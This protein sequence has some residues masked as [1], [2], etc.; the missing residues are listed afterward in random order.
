MHEFPHGGLWLN[1][2]IHMGECYA[3]AHPTGEVAEATMA[4]EQTAM[5]IAAITPTAPKE[6]GMIG[7]H[8]GIKYS[9]D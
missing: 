2:T 4:M 8:S 7:E 5:S 9:L 1:D 3:L 6:T